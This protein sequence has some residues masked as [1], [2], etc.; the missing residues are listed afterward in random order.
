MHLSTCDC[1]APL[2]QVALPLA[3][4]AGRV[5]CVRLVLLAAEVGPK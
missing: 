2:A 5:A 4:E 3:G 1:A